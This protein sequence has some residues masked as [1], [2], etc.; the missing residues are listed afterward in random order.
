MEDKKAHCIALFK[1][2]QALLHNHLKHLSWRD[3]LLGQD[4]GHR[5]R[6]RQDPARQD[7]H[8]RPRPL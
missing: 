8:R 4:P 7:L 5:A 1:D 6:P 2:N 3:V